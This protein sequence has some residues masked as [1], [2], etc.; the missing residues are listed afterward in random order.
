MSRESGKSAISRG[1]ACADFL[2]DTDFKVHTVAGL[3]PS[4]VK[5]RLKPNATYFAR[6]SAFTLFPSGR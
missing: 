2:S 5:N 6:Q 1:P 4:S 3:R